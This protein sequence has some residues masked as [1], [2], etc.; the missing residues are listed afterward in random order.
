MDGGRN[1]AVDP[2]V[3]QISVCAGGNPLELFENSGVI[4]DVKKTN[5]SGDILDGRVCR[6]QQRDGNIDSLVVDIFRQSGSGL[7]FEKSR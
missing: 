5:L 7:F 2:F 6:I 3:D 4:V 1:S